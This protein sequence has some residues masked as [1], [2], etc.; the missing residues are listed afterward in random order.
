MI[1]KKVQ[2][3]YLT[4]SE[5]EEV[6]R[7]GMASLDL[8]GKKVLAIIPD[9]TRTAPMPLLFRLLCQSIQSEQTQLDFLIALGT[10]PQIPE[11]E[12]L[13]HIGISKS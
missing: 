2:S 13:R 1:G 4:E 8:D 5:I 3:G 7:K 11:E 12:Q 6:I 10:H 9:T